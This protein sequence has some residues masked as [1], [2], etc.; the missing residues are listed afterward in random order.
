M[1]ESLVGSLLVPSRYTHNMR[2]RYTRR[3]QLY[4]PAATHEPRAYLTRNWLNKEQPAAA[5][6]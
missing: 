3:T 4:D 2:N 1:F 6:T 5:A